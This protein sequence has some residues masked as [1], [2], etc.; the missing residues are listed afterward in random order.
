MRNRVQ[1]EG[2]FDVGLSAVA[3]GTVDLGREIRNWMRAS[4]ATP[5]MHSER[6]R[7]CKGREKERMVNSLDLKAIEVALCWGRRR[8][9][10][11]TVLMQA[12]LN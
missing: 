12:K 6:L 4:R 9:N 10:A 11:T 7:F 3:K 5:R 8:A 2:S 1:A